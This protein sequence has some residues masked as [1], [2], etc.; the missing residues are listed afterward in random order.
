MRFH[1]LLAAAL[2]LAIVPFTPIASAQQSKLRVGDSAPALS[3]DEWV[4]GEGPGSF[5]ADRVYVVEFWATWCGPCRQSIPHL[6]E[7]HEQFSG[8]G[9]T[10]LG[11]SDEKP[12]VV[13]PWVQAK[14]SGMSYQVG[15]DPDKSMNQAWME[16]A[17]QKGIPAA[18]VVGKSGKIVYIGHPLDPEF[19]RVVRLALS[20]RFDPQIQAKAKPMIDAGRRAAKVKNWREAYRFFD[21]AIALDPKV[22]APAALERYKIQLTQQADLEGAAKYGRSLLQTYADD[23]AFLGDLAQALVTDPDVSPR[24]LELAKAAA[25]EMMKTA[26]RGNPLLLAKL[27]AVQFHTGEVD[28]AIETQ[29]EAWMSASKAEKAEFK[30]QLD[31]YRA[32][33]K[34]AATPGAP[35]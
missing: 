22:M 30:R 5:D 33:A 1:P 15:I 34:A 29:M 3:V 10:I 11:I 24:D 19:D 27:A 18:F 8:K 25:A 35:R 31:S 9:L 17:G 23:P 7:L 20:G 26:G 32:A 21:E 14:G 12:E 6:N 28:A 16:P 4:G 2:S 13:K